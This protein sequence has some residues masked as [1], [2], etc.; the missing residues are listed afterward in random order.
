MA[1]ATVIVGG[2]EAMK[3]I[4]IKN[5]D[6]VVDR[7]NFIVL[8]D[9]KGGRLGIADASGPLWKS[10]R[11]FFLHV[12]RDFGVGKPVLENTIITQASDVCAYFKSLNGQPITLTKIFSDKVDSVFCCQ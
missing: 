2:H 6:K 11:K 8:E 3:S 4:F 10:Q 9:I 1:N 5:G 7:T 12:L